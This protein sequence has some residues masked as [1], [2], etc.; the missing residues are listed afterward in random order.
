MS[1][2]IRVDLVVI[3]PQYDFVEPPILGVPNS[4]GALYVKGAEHDME[5]L[6][7]LVNRIAKKISSIAVSLDSHHL[8]DCAHP[9][10]WRDSAG[11]NPPP[12]TIISASDVENGRWTPYRPSLTKRMLDYVKTLEKGSR[13]PL[14]IWPPHCLIGSDGAAV[15]KGLNKAL[16]NWSRSSGK[17]IEWIA[18]GSNPF[19]EHYSAVRAEVPDPEDLENTGIKM[20]L[21]ESLKEA[22]IIAIAGEAGSHCVAN[23]VRDIANEFK[24][25]SYVKKI[26]LLE[27]CYSPVP[28]FEK[29]QDDFIAEMTKRGM[30]I[31]KASDFLS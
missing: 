27:G 20:G 14:C 30:R 5:R 15:H 18:K 4:G 29:M 8:L 23:T 9:E 1:K 25:D 11:K 3:D 10:F 28:G 16:N 12:F 19:T 31:E 24:D 6:T 17:R 7:T 26:V 22:D 13:Y 2:M 21:I